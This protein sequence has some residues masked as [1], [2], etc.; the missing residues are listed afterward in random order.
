MMRCLW[1]KRSVGALAL[2]GALA[3]AG[4]G[5]TSAKHPTPSSTVTGTPTVAATFTA[6]ATVAVGEIPQWCAIQQSDAAMFDGMIVGKLADLSNTAYPQAQIPNTTPAAPYNV[7][8]L[9]AYTYG[10]TDLQV[11]PRMDDNSGGDV[12]TICNTSSTS[13]QINSVTVT[14]ADAK[15]FTGSLNV[16]VPC[17]PYYQPANHTLT[18]N[19]C[20][21]ANIRNDYLQA[22][23]PANA[24]AGTTV[25]ANMYSVGTTSNPPL[26]PLPFSLP[27]NTAVT[28]GVFFSG[29]ANTITYTFSFGLSVSGAAAQTIATSQP[30]VLATPTQIWSGQNCTT[31]AMQA[32]IPA[33]GLFVC[34]PAS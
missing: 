28:F 25:T 32:K 14:I 26:G 29:L 21:G 11:N 2:I 5:T 10:P 18:G 27:P 34:P 22:T 16:W 23:F 15:P 6:A 17:N 13:Q 31:S 3:L 4:C 7:Q 9:P 24:G 8:G 20:G 1:D 30:T 33:T 19:G 12:L